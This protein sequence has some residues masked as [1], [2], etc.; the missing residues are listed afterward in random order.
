MTYKAF[1][2]LCRSFLQTTST[3]KIKLIKNIFFIFLLSFLIT[4]IINSFGFGIFFTIKQAIIKHYGDIHLS[5]KEKINIESYK[6]IKKKIIKLF[7]HAKIL[8]YGIENAYILE[9]TNSLL[10]IF[11]I[12]FSEPF[13]YFFTNK[14]ILN[15]KKF[16]AGNSLYRNLKNKKNIKLI[17]FEEHN[18]KKKCIFYST[19]PLT[20]EDQ[21]E[22]FNDELN[23]QGLIMSENIFYNA[24]EKLSLSEINI[25]LQ[26]DKKKN[27]K[28]IFNKTLHNF[29]HTLEYGEK[30]ETENTFFLFLYKICLHSILII[31]FLFSLIL[32]IKTMHFYI[33]ENKKDYNYFIIIGLR[34]KYIFYALSIILTIL[35]LIAWLLALSISLIVT[36]LINYLQIITYL[37]NT[38]FFF[39]SINWPILLYYT[40]LY[41]SFILIIL[42][43]HFK[44][45]LPFS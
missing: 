45:K 41:Y 38:Y 4:N 42:F 3:K 17:L 14:Q 25:Y 34:Y 8:S 27:Y 44:K 31:L 9:T 35:F 10:P 19:I 18:P 33:E 24:F 11:I 37:Y 28:K 6:K 21:I 2:Y 40:I 20:I 13:N 26:L 23:K 16:Y 29:P 43:I 1:F 5:L 7:P 39:C 32:L 30:I 15:N 12:T 36:F 22:F